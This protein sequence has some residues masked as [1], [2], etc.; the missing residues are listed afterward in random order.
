MENE[1]TISNYKDLMSFIKRDDVPLEF[2]AEVVQKFLKVLIMFDTDKDTLIK[3]TQ[4]HVDLF[5]QL[6]VDAEHPI[7]LHQEQL[8]NM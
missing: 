6:D 4:I 5:G 2:A 1:V 8:R 7:F 3:D